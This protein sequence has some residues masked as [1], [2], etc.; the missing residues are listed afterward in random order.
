MTE[1]KKTK[2]TPKFI[3][4][5]NLLLTYAQIPQNTT[6]GEILKQLQQLIEFKH[7]IIALERHK[8]GG[9]HT[10]ALLFLHKK[11]K[12]PLNYFEI[13]L[14]DKKIKGNY[15]PAGTPQNAIP[16]L[17]KERDYIT[18]LEINEEEGRLITTH[19]KLYIRS[20]EVGI[21][22]ALIEY[23]N[24]NPDAAM[25]NYSAVRSNL[26]KMQ[27]DEQKNNR[28]LSNTVALENTGISNQPELFTIIQHYLAHVEKRPR[29]II[30]AND[31][32]I[33]GQTGHGKSALG[34]AIANKVSN[35]FYRE[36]I[37]IE[38]VAETLTEDDRAIVIH[39]SN[40][41]EKYNTNAEKAKLH[42]GSGM[43]GARVLYKFLTFKA[44]IIKIY[45]IAS[46]KDHLGLTPDLQTLRRILILPV[47][48]KLNINWDNPEVKEPLVIPEETR[49][50]VEKIHY[51]FDPEI[52]KFNCWAIKTYCP[53]I[54]LPREVNEF[55][56]N[57]TKDSN[58]K[59]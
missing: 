6:H 30:E 44:G 39:E 14:S 31:L 55:L 43:A 27:A 57:E 24:K 13:T 4:A 32:V 37:D 23:K 19:E 45:T 41:D 28:V 35:G 12:K 2:T 49:K 21:L 53:E 58:I 50:K 56:P 52:I 15:Q 11:C 48:P 34:N 33:F 25:K 7:Y 36:V 59:K 9:L 22:P 38:Q 29:G 16:Y 1:N 3:Q 18:N 10:H 17:I 46:L 42:Q 26:F 54:Q 8:D 51:Q 5:K 47:E 20:K 40:I